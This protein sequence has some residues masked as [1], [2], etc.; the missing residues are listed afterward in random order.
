MAADKSTIWRELFEKWPASIPKRG[1]LVS[2]LNEV[3]PFKSF[4]LKGELL[5]LERTNPDPLGAR[6]LLM[7]YDAIHAVKLTEPLAESVFATAG[8]VGHLAKM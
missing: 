5:L 3:T 6:F 4:L 2:T 1:V 7:G 8:F